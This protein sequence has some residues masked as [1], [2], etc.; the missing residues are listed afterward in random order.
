MAALPK[1][2]TPCK[3]ARAG[4]KTD[5][6]RSGR[7]DFT[8]YARAKDDGLHQLELTVPDI[9][10]AGCI[11]RIERALGEYPGVAAARVNM[12]S[13]RVRVSWDP[14]RADAN[15]LAHLVEAQGFAVHPYEA[16][17]ASVAGRKARGRELLLAMAVA[18]FAAANVMLLSVSVWSGAGDATRA[19]FHWI[20]ALIAMPAVLFSGR[21]FFRSA[22]SALKAR[23]L[24]MDV[25]ISLAV[26][27]A[28]GMS[29]YETL[30]NG[31]HAYFDAAVMLLFFLLIGRY[32]DHLM[33]DRAH[34]A[35]NQLVS[36]AAPAAMVEAADGTLTSTDIADIDPGMRVV[37][38]PGDVM[39]VDGIV[40]QGKSD[41]DTS[42]MTGESVPVSVAPGDQVLEGTGNITG[43]ITVRVTSAGTDTLLA[44]ITCMMEQAEASKAHYV[45]LADMAA[46]VY[47]P[48]VH[49]VALATFCGWLWASGGD[50]HFALL[51]AIAV[52]I[53]T[54]PC[55]LGLAVPVVQTVASGV[56]FRNSILLKDGS[57]LERMAQID[58]VVF[59]K[60]GT[61]TRGEP[62]LVSPAVIDTER[63]AIAA[64]LAMHSRHPLS[65]AV[66]ALA[67]ARG[68]DPADVG[69]V[70]EEPGLGLEGTHEGT[71]VRLGKRSWC[72]P[73]EAAPD[74]GEGQLEL[75]LRDGSGE[76]LVLCFEDA[77][78]DDAGEVVAELTRRG[79]PPTLLSGDRPGA[80][81]RVAEALGI[82]ESLAEWTPE[83]KAAY[84]ARRGNSGRKV[85]MVGDGLNDAPALASAHA[86][87]APS[88]AADAGRT[89][90]DMVFLRDRLESVLVAIDT[91]KRARRLV[92][93][94]FALAAG[95]NLI[96]VP[97][98]IAGYATPLVAA[99]AMS[100]SSVLVT[101]NALRLRLTA[102]GMSDPQDHPGETVDRREAA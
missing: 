69:N 35:L 85:L 43:Q 26:V 90:A 1:Q 34:S 41:V 59:D 55:A 49:L 100:L 67:A 4:A 99:I 37:V 71:C 70:C 7:F 82:T 8:V 33:R 51:T 77:I 86:S 79:L 20:S 38:E 94:N 68:I 11:A 93:Q 66:A 39:P 14:Q 52:L 96:A 61:L 80:V 65:R 101:A 102:A 47:A 32:L 21:V 54:C 12:S 25:P 45:R 18:G 62:K 17:G 15:D 29:L 13:K 91:A 36:L 16:G 98:A 44:S 95:Y 76:P 58:A 46:R 24:N 64:G 28:C 84:V 63:L 83:K 42:A 30:H 9:H 88:T 78:R 74:A 5:A 89:A 10:C 6:R 23:T 75:L 87:M 3:P 72:L 73:G 19:M 27:L 53:I 56:L 60:T 92:M 40:V 81:A 50:W 57:A 48:V 22:W 2:R 31:P 97:L